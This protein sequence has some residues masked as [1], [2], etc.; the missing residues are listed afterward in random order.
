[1]STEQKSQLGSLSSRFLAISSREQSLI[2]ICGLILIGFTGF[3]LLLEPQ[4]T[5]I[6]KHQQDITSTKNKLNQLSTQIEVLQAELKKD[7]DASLKER[8]V[9]L[10]QKISEV[11]HKLLE[12][13]R[14]LVPVEQVANMLENVLAQSQGVELIEL[15]SIK[16]EPIYLSEPLEG[17]TPKADLY[18][19]G[20]RLRVQ[21]SY[22]DIHA[23]LAKLE[24]LEWQFY[25]K[26]LDYQVDSYPVGKIELEI[27]TLSTSEQF[28]SV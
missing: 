20:V 24:A 15:A 7:P 11:E 17:R 21:G 5:L 16:P 4:Q 9:L 8:I 22:F 25:W 13:T 10:D 26:K 14:H 2:L 19:H 3:S 12:Q 18:R 27:Y 6:V 1:M 28:V 23:Y